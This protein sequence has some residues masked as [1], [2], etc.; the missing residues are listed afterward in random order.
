MRSSASRKRRTGGIVQTIASL[1]AL[2]GALLALRWNVLVLV[3]VVGA[4]LPLV[5]LIDIAR[6]EGA[7]TLAA[8]MVVTVICIEAGYIAALFANVLVDA[9]RIAF[10]MT[11]LDKGVD[12]LTP[13]PRTAPGRRRVRD[14]N[15]R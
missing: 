12:R 4:A 1:S 15:A 8:D 3:P 14:T 7:G 2:I 5:A 13:A 10:M 6:G 9:T 11:L